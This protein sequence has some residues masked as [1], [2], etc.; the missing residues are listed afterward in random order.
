M[1][2]TSSIHTLAPEKE[3]LQ[4]WIHY[5]LYFSVHPKNS[6]YAEHIDIPVPNPVFAS[7]DLSSFQLT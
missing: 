6:S 5:S 3:L 2:Y 4:F 1:E 7:L